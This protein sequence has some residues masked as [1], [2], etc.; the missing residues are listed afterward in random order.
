LIM[1]CKTFRRYATIMSVLIM[2]LITINPAAKASSVATDG[3]LSA[4]YVYDGSKTK[5]RDEDAAAI[6][7]MFYAF[8]LFRGGRL[9]TSHW[10]NVK[11]FKAYLEKHPHITPILSIGGW[12]ADGF[13]Q[14]A[15]TEEGR[16]TFARQAVALM[17][18]YG[19]AGVDIDWEYPGL[20]V[21][22]IKSSPADRTNYTLLLRALRSNLD[23]LTEADGKPRRLC[24]ALSGSPDMISNLQCSEIGA[25]VDQVNLMTY[26][27]QMPGIASHHTA[28][29]ASNPQALSASAGLQAY[30]AAGIPAAKIMLGVAFYGYRWRTKE[31]EP[32]YRKATQKDTLPYTTIS[33]MIQKRADADY[34]D[35]TAQAPYYA[36]GKVFISY[37][38]A[39][40]I[41]HKRLYAKEHELMGLFAWS[42][43][44]DA[45]GTLIGAMRGR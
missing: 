9:S 13:S 5:Y 14:A 10:K 40:S 29:Y 12:G 32:L 45:T 17:E 31:S 24:I 38:D 41:E 33:K 8:A 23:A 2:T 37:D 18:E 39:R 22:G 26:D 44:S 42:Y 27:Q 11:A 30:V 15:A 4:V 43:G 7:Q 34:Y 21:A 20:S 25:V 3:L 35:A 16:K 1:V 36:D 28:L 6:D 19:F